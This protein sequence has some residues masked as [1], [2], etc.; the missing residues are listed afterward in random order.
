MTNT[1]I[2][3]AIADRT[4]WLAFRTDWRLRYVQASEDV[5]EA[6]RT[7][8]ATYAAGRDASGDQSALHY[9]RVAANRLMLELDKAKEAK[10]E[11]MAEAA[12]EA[13]P[14]AKAA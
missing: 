12:E 11:R 5:R 8:R 1:T 7:L 2:E 4:S 6:K 9:V 3:T 14:A 10:A 13:K